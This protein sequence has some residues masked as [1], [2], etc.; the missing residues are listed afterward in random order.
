MTS[1]LNATGWLATAALGAALA[2]PADAHD[3]RRCNASPSPHARST[4]V[5]PVNA[6][7]HG[8]AP[9]AVEGS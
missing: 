7:L 5:P 2:L 6:R 8:T 4:Y 3:N 1:P 9:A